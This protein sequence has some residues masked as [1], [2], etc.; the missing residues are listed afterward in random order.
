[1]GNEIRAARKEEINEIM[2][3]IAKCV[4]VMQAGGSDQWDEHYPNKEVIGKDIDSGTLYVYED[5]H[6]IAGLI[7]LDELQA[8]VYHSI[9]WV[10]QEGP[11]LMMHRL[12]VHPEVQGKGIARKLTVF[13]EELARAKGYTSIRL[14]TYSKN[15]RALQLY[16]RMGYDRRGEF[17]FV[18]RTGHFIALEKVLKP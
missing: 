6:A 14:D 9:P 11:H 2:E 17:L 10:K 4:Q 18:G 3:L 5:N 15:G 16:A 7:V 13:G 8:E 1:M 12:A